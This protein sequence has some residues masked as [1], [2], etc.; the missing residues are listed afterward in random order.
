MGQTSDHILVFV[1]DKS[2]KIYRGMHLKHALISYDYALYKAA[3]EGTI[4]IEDENGFRIGLEG[5]LHEGAKIYTRPV[6]D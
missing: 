6:R 1:N 2:V 5:S 3:V 4:L